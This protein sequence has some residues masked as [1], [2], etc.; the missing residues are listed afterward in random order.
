MACANTSGASGRCSRDDARRFSSW[1]GR[2]EEPRKL[3]PT[4][5]SRRGA[6]T[7]NEDRELTLSGG[8]CCPGDPKLLHPTAQRARMKVQQVRRAVRSSRAETLDATDCAAPE[9]W[10]PPFP[11]RRPGV[12]VTPYECRTHHQREFHM[13]VSPDDFR[14]WSL[15]E[16]SRLSPGPVIE[17]APKSKSPGW[18]ETGPR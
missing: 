6:Q 13:P 18:C 10:G 1:S 4:L 12:A 11:Q 15:R 14:W 9:C 3:A 5:T 8:L 2:D 17:C 7:G 16:R